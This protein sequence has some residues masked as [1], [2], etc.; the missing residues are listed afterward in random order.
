[1]HRLQVFLVTTV[2]KS[3]RVVAKAAN[4]EEFCKFNLSFPLESRTKFSIHERG[5]DGE[6]QQIRAHKCTM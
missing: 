5:S 4:N 6:S 3:K 1:M 2:K